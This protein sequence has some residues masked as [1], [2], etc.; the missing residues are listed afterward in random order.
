MHTTNVCHTSNVTTYI[1]Y[2]DDLQAL[3]GRH[4]IAQG[5]NPV[6]MEFT[7]K[8]PLHAPKARGGEVKN[9]GIS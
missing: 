7:K 4:N 8:P 2:A 5:V 1:G 3:K 9:W 6:Y